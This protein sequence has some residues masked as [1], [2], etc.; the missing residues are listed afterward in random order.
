MFDWCDTYIM[1]CMYICLIGYTYIF[2]LQN[3]EYDQEIP[4]SQTA[5]KSKTKCLISIR[6]KRDIGDVIVPLMLWQMSLNQVLSCQP[7]VTLTSHLFTK[8]SGTPNR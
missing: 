1:F 2:L 3:N 5:D 8:L 7:R 4:Q 6:R